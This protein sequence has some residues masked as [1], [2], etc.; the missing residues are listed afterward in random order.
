MKRVSISLA[1][2][3]TA[4]TFTLNA[5]DLTEAAQAQQKV[6]SAQE[7]EDALY[8]KVKSIERSVKDKVSLLNYE[9]FKEARQAGIQVQPTEREIEDLNR[10]QENSG[11]WGYSVK[12]YENGYFST[13]TDSLT[14][15]YDSAFSVKGYGLVIASAY[16][17]DNNFNDSGKFS[18]DCQIEIY[19]GRHSNKF[20]CAAL[21]NGEI[22]KN[23]I[24]S[25]KEMLT[26]EITEKGAT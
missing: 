21:Y 5:A 25:M 20:N 12:N 11:V 14:R 18:P 8:E 7:Q 15:T 22:D 3:L 17:R 6:L 26:K 23:A 10:Q 24:D 13:L 4:C 2:T 9:L 16:I 19:I 1:L